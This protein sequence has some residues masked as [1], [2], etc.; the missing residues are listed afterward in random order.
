MNV[1]VRRIVVEL[2]R[3]SW[4]VQNSELK[5]GLLIVADRNFALWSEFRKARNEWIVDHD[6]AKR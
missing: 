4:R 5:M 6:K 3:K 1:S 2:Y